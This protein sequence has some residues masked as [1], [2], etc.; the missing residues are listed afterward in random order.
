[1]FHRSRDNFLTPLTK[2]GNALNAMT[3]SCWHNMNMNGAVKTSNNWEI[4]VFFR[5]RDDVFVL[6]KLDK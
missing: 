5:F 4:G 6:F 3:K 1:M 2:S